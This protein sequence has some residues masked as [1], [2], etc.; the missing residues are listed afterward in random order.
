MSAFEAR[1]SGYTG[2]KLGEWIT[3]FKLAKSKIPT[4]LDELGV[5]EL[6]DISS[7]LLDGSLL[8]ELESKLSKIDFSKFKMAANETTILKDAVGRSGSK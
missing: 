1:D 3:H 6:E 7:I 5:N 2:T 8:D 4:A